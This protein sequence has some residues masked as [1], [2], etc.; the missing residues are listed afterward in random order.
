[1]P[2]FRV[3]KVLYGHKVQV[4]IATRNYETKVFLS[5]RFRPKKYK[6]E[7]VVFPATNR[8]SSDL[9]D[10]K[11]YS[12]YAY[13]TKGL[14]KGDLILNQSFFVQGETKRR[15]HQTMQLQPNKDTDVNECQD[16]I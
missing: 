3:D 10:L 1:M 2:G 16:V 8:F 9:S 14:G 11:F 7:V 6:T 5:Q 15:F 12:S 4:P 13:F